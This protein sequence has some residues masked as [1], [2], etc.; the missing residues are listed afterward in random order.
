MM[1]V[2]T[3]ALGIDVSLDCTRVQWYAW[4]APLLYPLCY[5]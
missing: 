3:Y 2:S 4:P 1:E 5:P